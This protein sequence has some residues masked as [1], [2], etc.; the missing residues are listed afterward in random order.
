MKAIAA[1]TAARFGGIDILV[2]NAGVGAWT[3]PRAAEADLEA[4]IDVNVKARTLPGRPAVVI[5]SRNADLVTIAAK[6]ADAACPSKRPTAH[7]SSPG[8]PDQ[9]LDYDA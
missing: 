3:L 8:R 5:K 4:M 2:I 6:P 1:G 9:R 7:R